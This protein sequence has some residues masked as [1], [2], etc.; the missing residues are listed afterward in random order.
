MA[1]R[2]TLLRQTADLAADFLETVGTRRVGA[3]ATLEELRAG[4]GGALPAR[5]E[6]SGVVVGNLAVAADPG[7]VASAPTGRRAPGTR[8]PCSMR[9]RPRRPWSRKSRRAG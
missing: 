8:T 3:S 2:R 5:G 7:L 1:D 4:L 9:C 6:T